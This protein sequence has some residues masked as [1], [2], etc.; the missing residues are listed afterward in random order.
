MA[1]GCRHF[2]VDVWVLCTEWQATCKR[3]TTVSFFLPAWFFFRMKKN[4]HHW[5]FL[6]C[7]IYLLYIINSFAVTYSVL[8]LTVKC[9]FRMLLCC[10]VGFRKINLLILI[11]LQSLFLIK[12]KEIQAI[13]FLGVTRLNVTLT[14]FWL[15]SGSIILKFLCLKRP[16]FN[17][18]FG[19]YSY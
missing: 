5:Q 12:E 7:T 10:S 17:L 1:W 2:L 11:F 4:V 6:W 18:H 3:W 14:L 15:P 16:L 8:C 13:C 19:V 9:C